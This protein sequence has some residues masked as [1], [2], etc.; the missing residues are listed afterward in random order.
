MNGRIGKWMDSKSDTT[1]AHLAKGLQLLLLPFVI[2]V[3]WLHDCT[4]H[5][6]REQLGGLGHMKRKER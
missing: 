3:H 5:G 2:L 4:R 1:K 6:A